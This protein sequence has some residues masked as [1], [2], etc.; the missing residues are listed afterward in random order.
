MIF[1]QNI[2]STELIDFLSAL[3]NNRKYFNLDGFA[4]VCV[5]C[6]KAKYVPSNWKRRFVPAIEQIEYQRI[7]TS[8]QVDLAFALCELGIYHEGIM[9]NVMES[10]DIRVSNKKNEDQFNEIVEHFIDD[11]SDKIKSKG[12]STYLRWLTSDLEK[13]VGKN[14][15]LNN[16][17]ISDNSIVPIV[18]KVNT[19]TGNFVNMKANATNENL[20]SKQNELM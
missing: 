11:M 10:D 14:K 19:K 13:F 3:F 4:T 17:T 2:T 18:M 9:E 20:T 8:K 12:M 15:I 5:A 7:D 1:F 6:A 16:V